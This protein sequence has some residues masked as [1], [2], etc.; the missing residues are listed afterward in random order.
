M[1]IISEFLKLP[2][3]TP[4]CCFG[5]RV[6][7]AWVENIAF[8]IGGQCAENDLELV[9]GGAVGID[10]EFIRGGART[11]P[12]VQSPYKKYKPTFKSKIYRPKS[13]KVHHLFE[14]T[15][16]AISYTSCCLGRVIVFI[17][18]Q[19]YLQCRGGSWYSL[20]FAIN[21]G[22]ETLQIIYDENSIT[23]DTFNLKTNPIIN[24]SFHQYS[25]N[26]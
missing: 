11:F 9:S 3:N 17:S 6:A 15:R 12:T 13:G 21:R 4:L 5:P 1:H 19:K 14:R 20:N 18:R 24:N 10:S 23:L 8:H 2:Y 22:T 26:L 7:P 25:L 16:E